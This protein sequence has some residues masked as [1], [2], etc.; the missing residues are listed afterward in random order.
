MAGRSTNGSIGRTISLL[1][2]WEFISEYRV[3]RLELEQRNVGEVF[4]QITVV[5]LGFV[6]L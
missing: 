4:G 2:Q 3:Y 5:Q 6:L 1:R